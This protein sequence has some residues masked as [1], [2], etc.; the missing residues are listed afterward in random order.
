MITRYTE[1]STVYG[2]S[3]YSSE[4]ILNKKALELTHILLSIDNFYLA[5][6]P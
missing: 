4:P 6:S 1:A 2:D 5:K 3:D